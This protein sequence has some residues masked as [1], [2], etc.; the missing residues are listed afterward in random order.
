MLLACC[1][2]FYGL[3]GEKSINAKNL[4]N[5]QKLFIVRLCSAPFVEEA[6]VACVEYL[7]LLQGVKEGR[8]LM[9]SDSGSLSL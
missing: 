2:G 9:A 5:G 3:V 7:P 1:L 4:M 8:M 6:R